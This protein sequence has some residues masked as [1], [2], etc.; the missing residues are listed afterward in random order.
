[1]KEEDEDSKVERDWAV[2]DL[3]AKSSRKET[4][5]IKKQIVYYYNNYYL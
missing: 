5:D 3:R 2:K 4:D 1:M